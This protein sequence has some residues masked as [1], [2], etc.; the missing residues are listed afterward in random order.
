MTE[1]DCLSYCYKNGWHWFER[2]R[3]GKQI[4]L[5]DVLDRVSCWC[6]RNKN[7][8]ELKNIYLF[9]PEYWEKLK[10]LQ[11]Q[12]ERPMKKFVRN[13]IPYGNVFDMEKI[14]ENEII[15]TQNSPMVSYETNSKSINEEQEVKT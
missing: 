9:L 4:E 11:V 7:R 8:K 12:I 6:C 13:G 14:F 3:D 5:Y 2:T 1:A 15:S 10:T